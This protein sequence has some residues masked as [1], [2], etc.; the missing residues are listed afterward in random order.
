MAADPQDAGLRERGM[1][2]T[3]RG[4][5]ESGP[6]LFT[7]RG[8]T[9]AAEHDLHAPVVA[10]APSALRTASRARHARKAAGALPAGLLTPPPASPAV[11][12][13]IGSPAT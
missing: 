2:Q 12:S 3:R 5:R 8:F 9:R 10:W 11:L 4:P 1:E 13:R 7:G 6:P